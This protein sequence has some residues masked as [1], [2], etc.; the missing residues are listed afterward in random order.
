MPDATS[1]EATD[2]STEEAPEVIENLNAPEEA[3]EEVEKPE[4]E[5]DWIAVESRSAASDAGTS[6]TGHGIS[7]NDVRTDATLFG[8]F[9]RLPGC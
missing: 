6:S 2:G 8:M 7:D 9:E 1:V 3:Q 5:E 4:A